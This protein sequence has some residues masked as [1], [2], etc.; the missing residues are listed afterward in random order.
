M[1]ESCT[2]YQTVDVVAKRWSLLIIL[3]IYKNNSKKRYSEIKKDLKEITPKI[4]SSRLKE[5]E[6]ENIIK[7]E[8]DVSTIP[9]KTYYSLT[10]S[11]KD[12]M[13]IIE[14]IKKW[15]IKWQTK[16]KRCNST[17]CKNCNL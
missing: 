13:K 7:K 12:L 17:F 1:N 9:L 2:V 15:G 6:E 16:S 5:L 10:D 3:S 14:E 8:I 11:G 4:L